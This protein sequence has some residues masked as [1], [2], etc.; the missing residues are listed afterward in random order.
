MYLFKAVK[1]SRTAWKKIAMMMKNTLV[2]TGRLT[3]I[4][5]ETERHLNNGQQNAKMAI[6]M[7]HKVKDKD[8]DK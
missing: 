7:T 8:K 2:M 1:S 5:L 3:K 4:C 6:T